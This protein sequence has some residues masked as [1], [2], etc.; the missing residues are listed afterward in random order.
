MLEYYQLSRYMREN[1]NFLTQLRIVVNI[2]LYFILFL[3]VFIFNNY[4]FCTQ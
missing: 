1:I 3:L 4:L 2:M